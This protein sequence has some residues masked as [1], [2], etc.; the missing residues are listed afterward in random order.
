MSETVAEAMEASPATSSSVS[1]PRGTKRYVY[2]TSNTGQRR[3]YY[4]NQSTGKRVYS[5][6]PVKKSRL[7]TRAPSRKPA[8]AKKRKSRPGKCTG[9]KNAATKKKI[10]NT[11]TALRKQLAKIKA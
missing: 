5:N 11:L 4:I 9:T 3:R 7:I 8:S 2:Y 6:V 10:G 1:R